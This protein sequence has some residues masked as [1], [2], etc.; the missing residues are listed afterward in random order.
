MSA[1]FNHDLL[2]PLKARGRSWEESGR[3]KNLDEL[4]DDGEIHPCVFLLC[5][6]LMLAVVLAAIREV[7]SILG[8]Q[9]AQLRSDEL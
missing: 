7:F 1:R 9:P 6:A 3:K 8:R 4:D 5:A 2:G